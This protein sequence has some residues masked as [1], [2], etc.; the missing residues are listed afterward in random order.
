MIVKKSHIKRLIQERLS[1]SGT[2]F[3]LPDGNTVPFGSEDHINF[4][5]S[6]LTSLIHIRRGLPRA[7]RGGYYA[8]SRQNVNDVIAQIRKE[9]NAIADEINDTEVLTD[10]S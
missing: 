4:L 3:T 7:K 10:E 1:A 6:A 8:A 5:D 2:A 9:L